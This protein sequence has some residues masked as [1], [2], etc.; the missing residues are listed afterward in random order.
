M[1]ALI[2]PLVLYLPLDSPPQSSFD[3]P[4]QA[5][6]AYKKELVST[7]TDPYGLVVNLNNGSPAD[8]GDAAWRT[9]RLQSAP[10]LSVIN[11][12]RYRYCKHSAIS[13]G[14]TDALFATPSLAATTP[15]TNSSPK[16]L[17]VTT[18]GS[19]ATT[20]SRTSAKS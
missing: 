13:A 10:R 18:A 8:I 16:W 17:P 7:F 20:R 12:R 3:Q 14:G 2:L 1:N 15:A 4:D 5:Y 11:R 6:A 19:T 9:G